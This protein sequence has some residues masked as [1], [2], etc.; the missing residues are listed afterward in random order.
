MA[1]ISKRGDNWRVSISINGT[2]DTGTFPSKG[3]AQAWALMRES[4]LRLQVSGGIVQGRTCAQAFKRY[5]ENVSPTKRGERWELLRLAAFT[6][7][8]G[9]L[10]LLEL[11]PEKLGEWRDERLKSVLG[12]TVNRDLNLLS[13]VLTTARREWKWMGESPTKDVRRPKNPEHRDRRISEDE[14]ARILIS[15]GYDGVSPPVTVLNIVALVFLFAIETAMRAGEICKLERAWIEGA[16]AHLPGDVNKN[17]SRR[18]VP[19]SPRDQELLSLVQGEMV[20]GITSASLDANFRKAKKRAGIEDMKFHDTR[21]EAITRLA[22]K[23]DVLD[24]ARMTGHKD[25]K[26]LMT[27]YNA[28]PHDIAKRLI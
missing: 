27:Y 9:E 25:I 15:C 6:E 26:E 4:E 20:F 7:W 22:R 21:H 19:L 5:G 13:H 24:L 12:S 23:L 1:S 2:R 17:E 10:P 11:T 18:S 16:V 3:K 28:S 8:F 14:I